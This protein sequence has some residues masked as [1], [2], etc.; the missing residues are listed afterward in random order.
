MYLIDHLLHGADAGFGTQLQDGPHLRADAPPLSV[1]YPDQCVACSLPLLRDPPQP[2]HNSWGRCDGGLMAGS[3]I[4]AWGAGIM[5][6]NTAIIS[7]LGTT[8]R[9]QRT[10]L[11]L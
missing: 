1:D 8:T 3:A 10:A 11:P 5:G 7:F 9:L 4:V 6:L 2:I